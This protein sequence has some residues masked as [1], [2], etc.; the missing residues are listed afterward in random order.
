[1][2]SPETL[3]QAVGSA[4]AFNDI[5]KQ[6]TENAYDKNIFTPNTSNDL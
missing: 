5:T 4:C 2:I 6:N 1:M 3:S